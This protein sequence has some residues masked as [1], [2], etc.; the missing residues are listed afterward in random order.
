MPEIPT[1][2]R[3]GELLSHTLP[4]LFSALTFFMAVDVLSPYE[5]S[6]RANRDFSS[7]IAFIGFVVLLGT[8]LGVLIDGIHHTIIEHY[9]FFK[10]DDY[11]EIDSLLKGLS[12]PTNKERKK[13]EFLTHYYF[14]NIIGE[15]A[16]EIFEYLKN[17][18]YRYSEFNAN[19][20]IAL[21]PFSF[22]APF[23]LVDVLQ[24]S[25][26]GS[27]SLG[28]LSLI[29]AFVCLLNSYDALVQYHKYLY[30]VILGYL[31]FSKFI[32]YDYKGSKLVAT[33]KY[34]IIEKI[35]WRCKY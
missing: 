16:M 9:I 19:T 26:I 35:L 21:V 10:M 2:L 25:W 13:D 11:T 33:P 22:T 23:Y 8:T 3:F 34:K 12:N 14:S 28:L 6:L 32:E 31:E 24:V 29:T 18:V 30:S 4:G 1:Q 20:F 7:V 15:N 17:S 27:I 5:L